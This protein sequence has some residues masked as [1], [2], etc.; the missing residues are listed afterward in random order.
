M[1]LIRQFPIKA[2]EKTLKES[3][4][5]NQRKDTILDRGVNTLTRDQDQEG[6]NILRNIINS[7]SGNTNW[8]IPSNDGWNNICLNFPRIDGQIV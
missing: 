4:L 3:T 5:Q 2:Q 6:D 8:C 7:S 1:I